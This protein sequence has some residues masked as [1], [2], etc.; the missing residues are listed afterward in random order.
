ME[1]LDSLQKVKL[2]QDSVNPEI[3]QSLN[4]RNLT[5]RKAYTVKRQI[6]RLKECGNFLTLREWLEHDNQVTLKKGNFCMNH[7]MCRTCAIRRAAKVV[8]AY[9]VKVNHVLDEHKNLMPVMVTLS[10]KNTE[11][12]EEGTSRIRKAITQMMADR[13]RHINNPRNP[14]V[15][16]NKVQGS[17]KA[18]EVTNK[19]R[20]W[21]PHFHVMCL[22]DEYIDQ[23]KLSKEWQ[24]YTGD[25]YIVDVRKLTNIEEGLYEVLKYITKFSE[26]SPSQIADLHLVLGG[27]RLVDPQGLLRGVVVPESLEDEDLTGEYR[28]FWALWNRRGWKLIDETKRALMDCEVGMASV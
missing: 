14:S 23:K 4:D 10:L 11:N 20:G 25:S 15:E 27:K 28:E 24:K 12:L 3:I 1:L 19:G 22:I 6:A 2:W 17:I 7:L 21:H 8:A 18:L 5:R 13:R 9:Q 26:L 16:W